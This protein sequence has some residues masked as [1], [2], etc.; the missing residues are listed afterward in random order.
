M[1]ELLDIIDELNNADSD[2]LA[3]ILHNNNLR[4]RDVLPYLELPVICSLIGG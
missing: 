2:T 1:D 4:L 3:A